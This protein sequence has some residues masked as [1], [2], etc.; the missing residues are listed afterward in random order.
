M[1]S[2]DSRRR[3]GFREFIVSLIVRNLNQ[4]LHRQVESLIHHAND[5]R[6]S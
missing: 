5:G 2:E 4:A 1:A 6:E 3:D